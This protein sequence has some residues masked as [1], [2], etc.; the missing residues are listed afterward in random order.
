M[1]LRRARSCAHSTARRKGWNRDEL[2]PA[3]RALRGYCDAIGRDPLAIEWSEGLE[4]DD[5]ERFL[6]EDVERYVAMG[7]TQFTL[8]FNGPDWA[9]ERGGPWLEWRD[10]LNAGAAAVA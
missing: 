8:G 4:P 2:E 1:P 7:F 5:L 3:A 10:R 9:V 6:E